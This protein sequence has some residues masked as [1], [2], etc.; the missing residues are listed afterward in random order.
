ML[1][2]KMSLK[3]VAKEFGV[4]SRTVHNWVRSHGLP[5]VCIV[6]K[7]FVEPDALRAWWD[8]QKQQTQKGAGD[9]ITV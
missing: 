6:G 2:A 8:Q 1:I 7:V 9:G 5:T 4:T 3:E